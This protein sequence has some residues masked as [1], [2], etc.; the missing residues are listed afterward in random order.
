M[1]V[2]EK[3]KYS[4]YKSKTFRIPVEIINQL[5]QLANENNTSVN[6][7]V[8]QALEYSLAHTEKNASEE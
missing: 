5:E 2:F 8:I 4:E 1:L 6:K 7:I 3:E